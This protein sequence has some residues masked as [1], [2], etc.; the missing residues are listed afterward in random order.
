MIVQLDPWQQEVLNYE[1]DLLIAK[2][3]RIGATHVMGIKAIEYLIK[4]HNNHPSSQ[5]VCV[6]ITEDQ[7][8]LI[9]LFALQYAQEKYKKFIG[10]GKNK[11]TLNRIILI[12][13]GNKRILIA[14]PV[15]A[16]GDSIRG[17]EGQVLMVDEASKMPKL[18]WASAKPILLTTGGKIWMWS[19]F[20]GKKDYFW[21]SFNEAYNLKSPRARFK[22][23]FLNTED[24]IENRKISES[25][26]KQQRE[27]ALS[28]LKEERRDMTQAEYN[29]EYLAIPS[30]KLRQLFDEDLIT[31]CQTLDRPAMV[32]VGRFYLG[33]DVARLGEDQSTFEVVKKIDKD[34]YEHVEHLATSK[35]L[36][37]K[38]TD[39]IFQLEEK[40]KFQQIFI[41]A[42]GVGTGVFDQL[43]TDSRTKWK[44]VA[45][46][47]SSKPLDAEEKPKKTKIIEWDLYENLKQLMEQGKIKLLKSDEVFQSLYSIQYEYVGDKIIIT[48][49]DKHAA[50]GLVRGAWCSKDK[51]LNI[52]DFCKGLNKYGK[53][54]TIRTGY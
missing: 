44:S 2:G 20:F 24:V 5:I 53:R 38:T 1:G 15:G 42:Y 28:I 40:Y 41:D 54:R 18:F 4:H 46:G 19:T 17:F 31:S 45:L 36:T 11:P 23:W 13:N 9:I 34:H 30:D 51:T 49:S 22:P 14:K 8:Q 16:T 50:D 35:T 26:T 6:S 7:A 48:G 39:K 37:T 52:L 29:Q 32:G 27:D 10:K 33:V 47:H 21:K 43:L 3:R 12:V 25:W